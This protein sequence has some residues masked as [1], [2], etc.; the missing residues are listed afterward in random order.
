MLFFCWGSL[1][2][3]GEKAHMQNFQKIPGQSRGDFVYVSSSSVVFSAPK[4]L[5]LEISPPFM[6][7]FLGWQVCRTKLARKILFELRF[8]VRSMLRNFPKVFRPLFGGSKKSRKI[9]AKFPH[10]ISRQKSRK[11]HRW[12]SESGQRKQY[13]GFREKYHLSEGQDVTFF[14]PDMLPPPPQRQTNSL[15][16]SSL[17]CPCCFAFS[18]KLFQGAWKSFCTKCF[19][20]S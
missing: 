10:K 5:L 14:V 12:A 3:K 9:P 4:L 2:I 11:I 19:C 6:D 13:F 7:Q 20:T 15:R 16:E 17:L 1:L 8:F 18:P